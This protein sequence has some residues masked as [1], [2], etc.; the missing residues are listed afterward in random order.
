[1]PAIAGNRW[2]FGLALAK[3]SAVFA[4]L[5]CIAATAWVRAFFGFFWHAVSS[6]L[7]DA[8]LGSVYAW[9]TLPETVKFPAA[10]PFGML[11]TLPS[12]ELL[13]L[14]PLTCAVIRITM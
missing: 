10:R 13:F 2:M 5:R 3:R 11:L 14:S 4:A 1:M 9:N 7:N 12:L 6:S 8:F